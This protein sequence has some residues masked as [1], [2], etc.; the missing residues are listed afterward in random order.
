MKNSIGDK[1]FF[2]CNYILLGIFALTCLFPILHILALSLSDNTNVLA[3]TIFFLPK[4]IQFESY[5]R[6]IDGT[7]IVNAFKNSVVITVVGT[8]LCM[9]FTILAAYPLSRGYFYARKKLTLAIVFT[10]MF[11]G[12][13]IPSYL[14]VKGLGLV[15]TYGAL[16]IPGLVSAYNML[17]LKTFFEGIPDEMIDASRIDGCNEFQL[18]TRVIL[19]ISGPVLAT[20]TLLYGV[21]Y[22][23]SFMSVMI[24]INDSNKMNLTV[25]VQQM[26]TNQSMLENAVLSREETELLMT[27]EGIQSAAIMIMVIPMLLVYPF[28][29]KYF[30]KGVM[31]GSIKG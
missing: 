29:Q 2:T 6:L 16:W 17:I 22:W 31:L 26:I 21:G 25:L 9:F 12:G 11:S 18:L 8:L 20:L 13:L 27:P 7:N 24:Y 15:N 1:V 23:N 30:V 19:R 4:G 3:G 28:L 5:I 10:M 14:V